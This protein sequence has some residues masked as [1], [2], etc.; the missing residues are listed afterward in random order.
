MSSTVF[1]NVENH[2]LGKDHSNYYS[3]HIITLFFNRYKWLNKVYTECRQFC[4]AW[5]EI[6]CYLDISRHSVA[7]IKANDNDV[8]KRFSELIAVWLKQERPEQPQPTWK[9]MC[10]AIASVDRGSAEQIAKRHQCHC[11]KCKST[12]SLVSCSQTTKVSGKKMIDVTVVWLH[13][14]LFCVYTCLE[15]QCVCIGYTLRWKFLLDLSNWEAK[16]WGLINQ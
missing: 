1:A 10:N 9:V 8:N 3:S 7:T 4:A 15:Y 5:E 13:N 14:V 2:V 12:K 16:A 6:A 11:D